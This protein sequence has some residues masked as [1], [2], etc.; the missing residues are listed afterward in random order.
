MPRTRLW[1]AAILLGA[2]ALRLPA[3]GWGLAPAIPHVIASDFRCSYAFDEDDVLTAASFSKPAALDFDPRLYHWGTL[4]LHLMQFWM[5]A[6]ERSGFIGRAWR[7]AYYHMAPGAYER[8]YAA[9]RLLSIVIA[10]L[11]IAAVFALGR[12]AGGE[13]AGLWAA[14]LMAVSP[15]HLLASVQIRVDLT[16]IALVTAAIWMAL[17]SLP[18][19]GFLAGLAV[20]AKSIAL[21][22]VAPVAAVALWRRRASPGTWVRIAG[23]GLLGFVAGQPYVLIRSREMFGQG[24]EILRAN[25]SPPADFEIGVVELLATHAVNAVRFA[26]GV[27][28]F[29]LAA[30]GVWLMLRR[31]STADAV[32]LAALAGGIAGL[33]PLAWPLLR[34]QL[35]LL[36][37]LCVAAAFALVKLRPTH[38]RAAGAA[39]VAFPLFS[40]LAQLEYMRSPHPGNEALR[41]VL[42]AVPPGST[43]AR[44]TPEMPPLDR[45]IYPLGPNP[46]LRDLTGNPPEWVMTADLPGRDYPTANRK[47]LAEQY[48]V[49]GDFRIA[50]RFAWASLGEAA[51]PHD[52]KYTHPHIVLY[53]R[54]AR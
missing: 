21:C 53:Q 31:R 41:A 46:L 51:S 50:R 5:E 8:V 18:W 22:M 17:R 2:L 54:R 35:P 42:H 7:D 32:L 13:A 38:R 33:V 23:L 25:L 30:A 4:H 29:L 43:I 20:S 19:M 48:E 37:V 40:S 44:L 34:Y 12:E 11:S 6:A 24:Y 16:M 39:A 49:A 15:A 28:A 36:P 26:L 47:L 45:K 3:I 1:L 10:L 9:G 27:P 14:A 52:W